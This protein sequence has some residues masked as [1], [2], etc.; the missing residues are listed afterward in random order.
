MESEHGDKGRPGV[1]KGMSDF[2]EDL[3][4]SLDPPEATKVSEPRL[5]PPAIIEALGY[6]LRPTRGTRRS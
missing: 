4:S 6:L 5:D 1:F 2:P 3:M